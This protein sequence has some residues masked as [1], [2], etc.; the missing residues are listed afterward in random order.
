MHIAGT[1]SSFCVDKEDNTITPARDPNA[2]VK[3]VNIYLCID[4]P[5]EHD[6]SIIAKCVEVYINTKC[7]EYTVNFLQL[8]NV[9][10]PPHVV[11]DIIN[12]GLYVFTEMF[13]KL[14]L[15]ETT[16]VW[17]MYISCGQIRSILNNV[18][19]VLLNKNPSHHQC[20]YTINK[21]ELCILKQ[22][23]KEEKLKNMRLITSSL[24]E[25]FSNDKTIKYENIKP[26]FHSQ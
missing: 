15:K 26:K 9:K 4:L 7:P 5:L 21:N 20:H 17:F 25:L 13:K 19:V 12:D 24:D 3:P 1:S 23:S 6:I 11:Y 2:P 18:T 16:E 14:K 8:V 10:M 22:M